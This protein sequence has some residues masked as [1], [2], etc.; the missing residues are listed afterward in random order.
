MDHLQHNRDAWNRESSGGGEW[1]VPVSVETIAAAKAG[2]WRVILTPLKSVPRSWFGELRGKRV[3]CLASAGGQQAPILA[4]AGA[5]VISFDLSD[6]QLARDAEVAARDDL[7]LQC[8]R[9]DMAD[10]SHFPDASF[11][12]IFH[13]VSNV[14]VP[15][16]EQVWRECFRVLKPN[17]HLLAGYMNPSFFLF[18]HDE[19]IRSGRLEVKYSLPFAEPES[20]DEARRAEI[21]QGGRALEFSHSLTSQIGGQTKAGFVIVDLFE[22]H[23]TDELPFNAHSPSYIV[24]RAQKPAS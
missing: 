23:W 16:V 18:D 21:V 3:L 6:E 10:L 8:V 9:G 7:D 4:A 11:D 2:D 24:T 22:D 12:L 14:F 1:S 20:L 5:K 15:D 19:S 13:A 17:C